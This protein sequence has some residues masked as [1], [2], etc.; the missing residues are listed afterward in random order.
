MVSV[1]FISLGVLALGLL[2]ALGSFSAG[3][4]SFGAISFGLLSFGGISIGYFTFGGLSVGN[5]AIGGLAYG[6]RISYGGMALGGCPIDTHNGD[7]VFTRKEIEELIELN[8]SSVPNF[9]KQIFIGL[10]A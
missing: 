7:I 8:A 2:I 1:G 5:Y 4:L 6:R 10:G 3:L 9:I